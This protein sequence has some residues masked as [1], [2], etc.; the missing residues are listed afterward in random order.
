VG[1]ADDLALAEE[2][3]RALGD[4]ADQK[5]AIHHQAVH[6]RERIPAGGGAGRFAT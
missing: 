6:A 1:A 5:G 4:V 2:A 3:L